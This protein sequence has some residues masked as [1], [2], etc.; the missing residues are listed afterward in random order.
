MLK[1]GNS[2]MEYSTYLKNKHK[3]KPNPKVNVLDQYSSVQVQN[4]Y[5]QLTGTLNKSSSM[6]KKK[7]P[8]GF[9]GNNPAVRKTSMSY[10]YED[11]FSAKASLVHSRKNS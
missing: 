9:K 7:G 11:N 10:A 3:N 2:V 4:K 8:S 1:Y 5:G 6:M